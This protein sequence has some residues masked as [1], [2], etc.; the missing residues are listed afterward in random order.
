MSNKKPDPNVFARTILSE[1]AQ[2]HAIVAQMAA[3]VVDDVAI[4]RNLNAADNAEFHKNF[5]ALVDKKTK[6]IYSL[7]ADEVGVQLP[8]KEPGDLGE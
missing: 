7:Y 8:P 4:N 6:K 3:L 5:W 2:T 1:L